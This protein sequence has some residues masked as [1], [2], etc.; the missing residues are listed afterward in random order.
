M[1]SVHHCYS[2]DSEIKGQHLEISA[3]CKSKCKLSA[4]KC[5]IC[6]CSWC[7]RYC[8]YSEYLDAIKC[9]DCHSNNIKL[10]YPMTN[11]R[12]N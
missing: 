10:D 1:Q 7:D 3:P 6:V 8:K 12:K 11:S 9:N 2:C 5:G 4:M